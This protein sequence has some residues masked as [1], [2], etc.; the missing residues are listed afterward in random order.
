[1]ILYFVCDPNEKYKEGLSESYDLRHIFLLYPFWCLFC[2]RDEPLFWGR[3]DK[4]MGD[5]YLPNS[6]FPKPDGLDSDQN[7]AAKFNNKLQGQIIL[8][9]YNNHSYNFI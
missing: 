5:N 1:M 8:T 7:A 6:H 9:S 4:V 3:K 2:K